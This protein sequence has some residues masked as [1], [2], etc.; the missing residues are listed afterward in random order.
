MSPLVSFKPLL[1]EAGNLF[2]LGI[3]KLH[4]VIQQVSGKDVK[5]FVSLGVNNTEK[6]IDL[7]FLLDMIINL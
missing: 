7:R 2:P 4:G 3:H 6:G 1:P 5:V